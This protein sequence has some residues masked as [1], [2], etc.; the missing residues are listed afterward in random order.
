MRSGINFQWSSILALLAVAV[1]AGSC[2]KAPLLAPTN[3][4]ITV[5]APT[6]V[7]PLGGT[8]EITAFVV[9]QAGTPVQNGTTV[10]FVT[11]LG[12]VS[13]VDASTHNGMATTT[14]QAGDVSGVAEIRAISGNA[15]A[16]SSGNAGA[17][18]GGAGGAAG[19]PPPS[20]AGNVVQITVGAAAVETVTVRTNPATVSQ[21]G[22]TVD[23]IATVLAAGGRA[24]PGVTVTFSADHGTLS[25]TTAVSDAN[26]DARVQLTTNLD[27]NISA[28]AG[29]KTAATAA[30]VTAQPGPSVTLTC[31]SSTSGTCSTVNV[32]DVAAFT[33]ARGQTTSNIR[34]ALLD[35]GDGTTIELGNLSSQA[36][37]SHQYTQ[38]GTY[39]VRLVA[40][41][42]NGEVATSTLVIVVQEVVSISLSLTQT[43]AHGISAEATVIGCTAQ[44]YDWNFGNGATP[45]S[46]ST[47]GNTASSTYV[48][49]GTK[50]VIVSAR[51]TDGRTAQTSSQLDLP[52]P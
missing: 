2:N 31:A 8:T 18:S 45:A 32:G 30:K 15:G 6:R 48:A 51:C 22:G 1:A 35:F 26:G 9:E 3:S 16:G 5:S 14:F 36:T 10:H 23:V 37:V 25:S 43:G 39:V 42:V 40:T 13:P 44:R 47:G 33:L 24:V 52:L 29:S 11:S 19:T 38:T 27:T 28:T 49:G 12:T 7:L 41:D 4:N 20:T 21:N 50:T 34:S 46:F 17:G